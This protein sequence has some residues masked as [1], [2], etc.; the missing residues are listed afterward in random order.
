MLSLTI[1]ELISIAK[2]RNIDSYKG[3]SRK[4]LEDLFSKKPIN[5]N[6]YL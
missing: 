1:S 2:R 4:E 3:V 6:P 5:T